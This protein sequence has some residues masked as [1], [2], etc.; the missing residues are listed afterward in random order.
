MPRGGEKRGRGRTFHREWG[1]RKRGKEQTRKPDD[2][3]SIKTSLFLFEDLCLEIEL[4][5]ELADRGLKCGAWTIHWD[6]KGTLS[7]RTGL[8]LG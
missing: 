4:D 6:G 7:P 3:R 2:S 8:K 5:L 1:Q